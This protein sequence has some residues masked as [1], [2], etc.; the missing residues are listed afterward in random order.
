[1]GKICDI[2][3][4]YLNSPD[5]AVLLPADK[6]LRSKPYRGRS[7][8]LSMMPGLPEKRARDYARSGASSL[9]A[10]LN[11]AGGGGCPYL[12]RKSFSGFSRKIFGDLGGGVF[13]RG[14]AALSGRCGADCGA[15]TVRRG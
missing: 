2:A 14:F 13:G 5:S 1:M 7:L 3:G 9:F 10:A 6:Y 12:F 4:L 8:I 15:W 11:V